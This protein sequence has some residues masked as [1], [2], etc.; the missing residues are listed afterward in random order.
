MTETKLGY[1]EDRN[2][3]ESHVTIDFDYSGHGIDDYAVVLK[4]KDNCYPNTSIWLTPKAAR[5]LAKMLNDGA[6]VAES[7]NE[8][9]LKEELE[10]RGY[11]TD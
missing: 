8:K 11:R 10:Y 9:V 6:D 5:Q 1:V 7:E 3:D 2:G 4:A